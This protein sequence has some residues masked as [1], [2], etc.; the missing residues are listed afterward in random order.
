M[1]S[2]GM[3]AHIESVVAIDGED[4]SVLWL[5]DTEEGL[6]NRRF[7]CSCST[8]NAYSF[9]FIDLQVEVLQDYGQPF[10]VPCGIVFELY[11]GVLRPFLNN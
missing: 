2:E 6:N 10:I 9:K 8:N 7:S 11:C 3:K 1:L 4:R 5:K